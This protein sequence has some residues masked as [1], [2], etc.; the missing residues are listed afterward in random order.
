MFPFIFVDIIIVQAAEEV[1]KDPD[2]NSKGKKQC[3]DILRRKQEMM[4]VNMMSMNMNMAAMLA[5]DTGLMELRNPRVSGI[6]AES[7]LKRIFR[8]R[9]EHY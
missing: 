6:R 3:P 2:A 5:E 7:F 1:N 4:N 9:K 8:K